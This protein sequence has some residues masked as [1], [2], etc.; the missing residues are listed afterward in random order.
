MS[1]VTWP[2]ASRNSVR[3]ASPTRGLSSA[4]RVGVGVVAEE[5]GDPGR[6]PGGPGGERGGDVGLVGGDEGREVRGLAAGLEPLAP[7]EAGVPEVPLVRRAARRCG[8]SGRGG[9]RSRRV[10]RRGR[11]S[12]TIDRPQLG[13]RPQVAVRLVQLPRHED[14]GVAP[15]GR[16]VGGP[17]RK[18]LRSAARHRGDVGDAAVGPLVGGEVAQPLRGEA[19]DVV[20]ERRGR[21]EAAA[22]RR[23]SRRARG[24]GSRWG[25]RRRCRGSSTPRRRAAG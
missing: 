13:E 2:S 7:V 6:V 21:H 24:W 1:G 8:R 4:Y 25:C 14:G 9:A 22:S 19:G 5:G 23:S 15:A 20:E 3:H 12:A 10:R 17:P 16:A 11:P 18:P